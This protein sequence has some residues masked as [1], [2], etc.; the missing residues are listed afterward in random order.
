MPS[1]LFRSSVQQLYQDLLPP[2]KIEFGDRWPERHVAHPTGEPGAV[3]VPFHA[4]QDAGWESERRWVAIF[5]GTQS[6]KTAFDPWWLWREILR[7]GAGDYLA[8]TATYD[9]F[10]FKLLPAL[11]QAFEDILGVGRWWAAARMMELADPRSG[12]FM[13][14]HSDD[15]MWARIV[16]RSADAPGGLESGSAKAAILDEAGMYPL[17]VWR[18]VRRRLALHQGRALLSSTLYDPGWV[19]TEI[20]E[21]AQRGGDTTVTEQNGGEIEVTDNA[22]ADLT[23]IQCDSIVNPAYPREEYEMARTELPEEDFQAFHRGRRVASRLLI[24]DCFDNRLNKCPRFAI[25]DEWP[26]HLGIDPGGVNLAGIALAE[27]PK[28]GKDGLPPV[29]YAYQEYLAGGRT[30]AEHSEKLRGLAPVFGSVWGGAPSEDQWRREFAAG[31]F[32]EGTRVAGLPVRRPTVDDFD[33]QLERVYAQFKTRRLVVFDDLP[34][35]LREIRSY[36]RKRDRMGNPLHEVENKQQYHLLDALR[37]PVASLRPARRR[38]EGRV[39]A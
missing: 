14:R 11:R 13:A 15:I 25:P 1:D 35:L 28:S 4:A 33:S 30:A 27:D 10:K 19:D 16:L 23:L 39:M 29:L 32:V 38:I 2:T 24:Y 36:R 34:G 9:L 8:V 26:R 3:P 18:G 5:A 22:Q 12:Q 31:G 17:A 21:R 37:Y 20:I 7:R 6:G